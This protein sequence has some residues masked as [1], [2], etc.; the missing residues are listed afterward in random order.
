MIF[1]F[2]RFFQF[3]RCIPQQIYIASH[4]MYVLI[5]IPQRLPEITS[6]VNIRFSFLRIR[7]VESAHIIVV[8]G[9]RDGGCVHYFQY[10]VGGDEIAG[11]GAAMVDGGDT[12]EKNFCCDVSALMGCSRVLSCGEWDGAGESGCRGC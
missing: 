7:S 4:Q 6:L 8:V 9:K 10:G 2:F 3:T 12:E 1:V 5:C 11:A